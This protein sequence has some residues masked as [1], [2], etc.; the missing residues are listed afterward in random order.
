MKNLIMALGAV[1]ILISCSEE[2]LQIEHEI[3]NE[4]VKS[5][6][7]LRFSQND[8]LREKFGRALVKALHE[9][10]GLRKFIKEEASK[11]FNKDYDVLYHLVKNKSIDVQFRNSN[12]FNYDTFRSVLL[13]YFENES[14]LIQIENQLPLLTIFVPKLPENSFSVENWNPSDLNQLPAVALRMD[15]ENAVP[16]IYNSEIDF[17]LEA[18]YIP[19]FPV[20]VLKDNERIITSY[21]HGYEALNT[22]VF[23]A[24]N[25]M[26]FKII[27]ENLDPYI[28][29]WNPNF[30]NTLSPAPTSQTQDWLFIPGRENTVAPFLINA[31]NIFNGQV[32]NPWQRDNIYYGLTPTNNV[33]TM[34][35]LYQEAITYFKLEGN[36]LVVYNHISQRSPGN[37]DPALNGGVIGTQPGPAWT[38]GGYE[39]RV[40]WTHGSKTIPDGTNL[41][42]TFVASPDD[43]FNITYIRKAASQNIFTNAA[44]IALGIYLWEPNIT[45][46][47]PLDFYMN[48]YNGQHLIFADWDLVDFA[49][50]WS[51]KFEE[52]DIAVTNEIFESQTTRHNLN[53]EV[54]LSTGEKTKFGIKFGATQEQTHVDTRKWNYTTNGFNQLGSQLIHFNSN[55]VNRH[56]QTGIY[57][58]NVYNAGM[59][60]FELRPI[61][62]S[63]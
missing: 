44:L 31:Y 24:G 6:N 47:K 63:F 9:N 1:L 3:A 49:N 17:V 16:I 61:Q 59:V 18:K 50:R 20:V 27:D 28:T 35:N 38:D 62:T 15:E 51:F 11:Q 5:F 2:K 60:T 46:I 55:V 21:M 54:N 58:P 22:T 52:I 19:D 42:K 41:A 10:E 12:N 34:T 53:A 57:Y 48:G 43:I 7:D 56:P 4:E 29:P 37:P 13:S 32:S 36:P 45:S 33:G 25:N 8:K 14:D 26:S 23:D 40:W 39:F 30:E